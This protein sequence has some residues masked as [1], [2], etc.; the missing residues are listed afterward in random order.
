MPSKLTILDEG[1]II[2]KYKKVSQKKYFVK[3]KK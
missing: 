1:K 3:G 2:P